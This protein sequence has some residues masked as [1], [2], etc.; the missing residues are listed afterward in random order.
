MSI[1]PR[2]LIGQQIGKNG[3][4]LGASVTNQTDYIVVSDTASRHW[5]TTHY[6]TKIEAAFEKIHGGHQMRFVAESALAK[7]L[8][9][10]ST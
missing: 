4:S 1:G 9:R 2:S 3:G 6:G 5:K 7:A 8:A 10:V